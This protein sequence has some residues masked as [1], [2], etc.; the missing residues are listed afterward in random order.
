MMESSHRVDGLV[1]DIIFSGSVVL[2]KLTILHLVTLSNSVD[3]L[4][5]LSS[6]MVTLLTSTRYSKLNSARMPGSNTSYLPQTLVCLTGKLLCIPSASDTLESMTL[7]HSNN[8]YTLVHVKDTGDRNLLL[9]MFPGPLHLVGCAASVQLDLHDMS[10]LLHFTQNLHLCVSNNSDNT[11]ILLDLAQISL[12]LLLAQ[13]IGPLGGI[14]GE[15]LLLA[16]RP[17]L[18]ESSLTFLSNMF[19]P[20]CLEGSQSTRG[21]DVTND[22]NNNNWRSLKDGHSFSDLFLVTL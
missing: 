6:V 7:C 2:D 17:I 13:G 14:L 18:V 8:I 3:L 9:K 10:L 20:H 5:D 11:A 1:D 19:S 12:N 21:I 22:S 15:S 16:C 4:V